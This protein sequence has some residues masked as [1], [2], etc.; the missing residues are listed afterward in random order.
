MKSGQCLRKLGQRNVRVAR[1]HPARAL[2]GRVDAAAFGVDTLRI[3]DA[4]HA[5]QYRLARGRIGFSLGDRGFY[6]V[7]IDEQ[8]AF[9]IEA[10]TVTPVKNFQAFMR[11]RVRLIAL[12]EVIEQARS[13][14]EHPRAS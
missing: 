14:V 6:D 13:K 2:A 3:T 8:L 11:E 9:G 1:Q 7:F 4:Q 5:L 10:R 12:P